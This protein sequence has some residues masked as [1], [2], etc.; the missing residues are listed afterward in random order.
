MAYFHFKVV[1]YIGHLLPMLLLEPN[2]M[3]LNFLQSTPQSA[4]FILT[5]TNLIT[6]LN[7]LNIKSTM[8]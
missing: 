6:A 2:I 3:L 5:D 4:P 1:G 7:G 8:N